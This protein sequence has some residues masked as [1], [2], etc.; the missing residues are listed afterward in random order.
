MSDWVA[1]IHCRRR[2]VSVCL[3]ADGFEIM[4]GKSSCNP[5]NKWKVKHW[6]AWSC[7]NLLRRLKNYTWNCECSQKFLR[8]SICFV[9]DRM[10]F[11]HVSKDIWR[12]NFQD[13]WRFLVREALF[14][15]ESILKRIIILQSFGCPI[16]RQM[17][18]IWRIY[19]SPDDPKWQTSESQIWNYLSKDCGAFYTY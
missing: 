10:I 19:I 4:I 1:W 14:S 3:H 9:S 17:D 2:W 7:E 18:F 16:D 15:K 6:S 11:L 13:S 12:N 5:A 8:S